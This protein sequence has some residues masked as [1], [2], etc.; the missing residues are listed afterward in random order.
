MYFQISSI[1]KLDDCLPDIIE[2]SLGFK[3]SD[4]D[5]AM[6]TIRNFISGFIPDIM[7]GIESTYIDKLYRDAY[8]NYYSSKLSEYKRDCIRLSFFA[9]EITLDDFFSDK[10]IIKL[11][12]LFRGFVV[13]RPTVNN[14]IGRN[15]LHPSIFKKKL[16]YKVSVANFSACIYG[17]KLTVEGFP[18]SSQDAEFMVCAETTIWSA[19]EYFS[20]RYPEYR[21]ILPR[22]I[23]SILANTTMERQI[24]SNGLNGLQMSFALKELGFG[25]KIYYASQD[26]EFRYNQLLDFIKIY[27]ESG[28]PLMALMTNNTGIAHVV[29]IVGRTDF[30]SPILTIPITTLKNGGQ[31]FNFYSREAKYLLIDDNHHPYMEV[32]LE[33]PA[34]NYVKPEWKDCKIIG[35]VV[36]LHKKIYMEVLR[37]RE[38]ALTSLN[39]FDSLIKL[40]TLCLRLLLSSTRTF[41]HSVAH[42]PD[43]TQDYKTLLLGLN[44]SK[45]VWIA[46]VGTPE[47]FA[48][49]KATGMLL[50]DAT[51][52]K[53]NQILAYLLEN[54]Y[55][56][57]I[58]GEIKV[59]SLPLQPFKMHHNL[60]PF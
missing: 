18:H 29:N 12:S 4:R 46:E 38:L 28:I 41:K 16:E 51:E 23:H 57:K 32:P 34:C 53:K 42:N 7:I 49:G 50:M 11:E 3:D 13:I 60:K 33:D 56:G 20:T 6:N 43:L 30:V 55:I 44:M 19:M 27:V 8:Y 59:L 22:K 21:P 54:T 25:A 36:P 24:P 1:S 52:P 2:E 5:D 10:G 15:V 35:A 48:A 9:G 45:F 17:I 40:P 58:G 47:S 37:A 14:V 31:V 26:D 39:T